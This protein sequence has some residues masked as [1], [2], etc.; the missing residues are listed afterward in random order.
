MQADKLHPVREAQPI[1]L[2]NLWPAIKEILD[3]HRVWHIPQPA[4]HYIT[5]QLK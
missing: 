5:Q 3:K 1:I 2:E 4:A